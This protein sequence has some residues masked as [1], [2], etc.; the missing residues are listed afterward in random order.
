M[1]CV[2]V[3]GKT[4][5]AVLA[6]TLQM[7]HLKFRGSGKHRFHRMSTGICDMFAV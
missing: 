1:K 5:E 3:Y 7:H 4:S 2:A 6:Q